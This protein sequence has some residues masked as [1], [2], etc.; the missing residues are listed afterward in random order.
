MEGTTILKTTGITKTFP[1][2]RALSD[3]DFELYKGEVHALVGENGAGK[4]TLIKIL[5]GVYHCDQGSIFVEGRETPIRN[6]QDALHAGLRAVYQDVNLA[7][8]LTVGENFYLGKM[9]K[10]HGLIAWK[11]IFGQTQKVLDGLGLS[12]NARS[13]VRDLPIAQ[14]EM[15][16]IAKC[17]YEN[18]KIIIFDEPTALLTGEETQT[19]FQIIRKLKAQGISIIYISHRLEELFEICDRATVLK[20][21]MKV[22]TKEIRELTQKKMVQMMVGRNLGELYS[23]QS[24]KT[25]ETVLEVRNLTRNGAFED[26]SFCL[27]RGEIL[28]ISGLVGSGRTEIVRSI[29]GAEK[30]DSGTIIVHGKK[31]AIRKPQDAI[32]LGIGLLPEDRRAQGLSLSLPISFNI[33]AVSYRKYARY[34]LVNLAKEREIPEKYIKAV[35]IKTPSARQKAGK[36]SGGNQQKVVLGKWLAMDCDILMFD[37]P[38]VGVDVGTKQEI[39]RLIGELTEAGI[40]VIVIS[41]YL[42]EVMGLADEILVMYEGKVTGRISREEANEALLMNYASGLTG[43]E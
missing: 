38:T 3:V 17:T 37:E 28:G 32:A 23:I 19:L 35:R 43:E 31:A 34:G 21:G 36:L 20:D 42:P 11:D 30:A 12:I 27:H 24:H 7:S 14:Q 25:E 39:Y 13:R 26:V 6:E 4:S 15:V 2:V 5:M 10:R 16:C 40:A 9:P 33:N 1:G 18:A 22:D 41:S 29:F 8:H